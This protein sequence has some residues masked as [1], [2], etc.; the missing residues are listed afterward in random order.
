MPAVSNSSPLMWLAKAGR[1]ETLRNIFGEILVP[2]EVYREVVSE[3]LRLGFSD[4]LAVEEAVRAGWIKVIALTD[5]EEE[6][7]SRLIQ[8]AGEIH[9]GEAQAIALARGRGVP[10]LM[11]ESSGRALAEA[12]GIEA[13]GTIYVVLRALRQGLMDRGEAKETMN[14]MV[15]KGMRVDPRLLSRVLKEIDSYR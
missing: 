15:E 1:I 9:V 14:R 5:E 7:S 8:G 4:A 2:K 12:L 6:F 10:L 13:R 11:D 3:G